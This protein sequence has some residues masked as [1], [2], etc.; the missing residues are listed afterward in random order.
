M[1]YYSILGVPRTSTPAAIKKAY[2]QAVLAVHPD[3]IGTN[4]ANG[5]R[6]L[7]VKE[8]YEVLGNSERRTAYDIL[9]PELENVSKQPCQHGSCSSSDSTASTTERPVST[10]QNDDGDSRNVSSGNHIP[11][12]TP[13]RR[14]VEMKLPLSLEEL[15]R[16]CV[17]RYKVTRK[18]FD[19]DTYRLKSLDEVLEIP[20]Q[21]GWLEGTRITFAGKGNEILGAGPEDLVFVVVE[22]P[23]ATFERRGSDLHMRCAIPLVTAL[24]GGTLELTSL[25]ERRLTVRLGRMTGS[26]HVAVIPGE[27]MPFVDP[28]APSDP[29][30]TN[31]VQSTSAS[32]SKLKKGDLHIFLSIDFPKL[33][34]GQILAVRSVLLNSPSP[35]PSHLNALAPPLPEGLTMTESIQTSTSMSG[36]EG[37]GRASSTSQTPLFRPSIGSNPNNPNPNP[38]NPNPNNPNPNYIPNPS[39][40]SKPS[41]S[42]HLYSHLHFNTSV[43]SNSNNPELPVSASSFPQVPPVS[44][45]PSRSPLSPPVVSM[46]SSKPPSSP[47]AFDVVNT[48][49]TST[50]NVADDKTLSSTNAAASQPVD[51]WVKGLKRSI[52]DEDR[53]HYWS[54]HMESG[55][56]TVSGTNHQHHHHRHHSHHQIDMNGHNYSSDNHHPHSCNSCSIQ[57]NDSDMNGD[58]NGNSSINSAQ[59]STAGLESDNEARERGGSTRLGPHNSKRRILDCKDNS[60]FQM[61]SAS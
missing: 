49:V 17:K 41:P 27:G 3:K 39:P 14:I 51:D 28:N 37:M 60:N 25:D 30:S 57:N 48:T 15:Y 46:S 18:V 43:N 19:K 44:A 32:P 8:A 6:F 2:H 24:S 9:C 50:S 22:K 34:E 38:N 26:R 23:N 40:S 59:M 12:P 55:N 33:S 56:G 10:S 31:G 29:I 21:P 13:A 36:G 1:D 54:D 58:T 61:Y 52:M 47:N 5:N 11:P 4:L 16:G 7:N 53:Q 20:V 42:P 45:M 35:P